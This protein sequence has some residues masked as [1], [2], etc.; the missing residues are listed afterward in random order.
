MGKYLPEDYINFIS[1]YTPHFD[2]VDDKFEMFT[3]PTQHIR[4]NTIIELLN[5]GIECAK[6]QNGKSGMMHL[7]EDIYDS[8]IPQAPKD[9]DIGKI[10]DYIKY[11]KEK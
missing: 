10:I 6:N 2:K 1:E 5:Y 7:I 4:D 3:V 9:F 8:E 11:E